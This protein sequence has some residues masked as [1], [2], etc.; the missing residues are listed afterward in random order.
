MFTGEWPRRLRVDKWRVLDRKYPTLAE[1]VSSHGYTIAGF[2]A[3]QLFGN[4]N[5]GLAR[6]FAHY[7]DK[8]ISA[9][10]PS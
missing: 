3:N 9:V 7:E 1:V 2:V 6:R 8:P 4:R 10:V 5:F